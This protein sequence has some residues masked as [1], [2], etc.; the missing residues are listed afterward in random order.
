MTFMGLVEAP[1]LAAL[2]PPCWPRP[3]PV[4]AA[5]PKRIRGAVRNR[6]GDG[7]HDGPPN[8]RP[9]GVA[10]AA[11]PARPRCRPTAGLYHIVEGHDLLHPGQGMKLLDLT[12]HYTHDDNASPIS[13]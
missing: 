10:T 9:H 2:G 7:T 8:P 5:I 11:A 13:A 4:P 3:R 12:G 1:A 6:L